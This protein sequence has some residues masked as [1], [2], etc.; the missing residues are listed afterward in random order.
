[1]LKIKID[2][3]TLFQRAPKKLDDNFG[4]YLITGYQ[5]SGKTYYSIYL[6]ENHRNRHVRNICEDLLFIIICLMI[7]LVIFGIPIL[8]SLD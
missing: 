4:I 7:G 6:M 3:K 8:L 1:M 5:G 2:F